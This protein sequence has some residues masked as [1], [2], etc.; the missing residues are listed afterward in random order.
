MSDAVKAPL[1][2]FY[3]WEATTPEQVFLRQPVDQQWREYTWSEV[4]DRVRRLANFIRAQDFPQGSSI[5]LFSANCADWFM[6]D[7]A[8]MLSGPGPGCRCHPIYSGA[9]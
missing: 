8:I 5:A 6:V 3:H 7:L 9:Q 4:A 1:E 2:M